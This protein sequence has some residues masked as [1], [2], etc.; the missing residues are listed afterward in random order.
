MRSKT[1]WVEVAMRK[2]IPAFEKAGTMLAA[3]PPWMV[4]MFIVVFPK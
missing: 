2:E 3:S 4:P 1:S